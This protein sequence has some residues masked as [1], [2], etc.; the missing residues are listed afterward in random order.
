M[1]L[2]IVPRQ[3][4]QIEINIQVLGSQKKPVKT[5]DIKIVAGDA[6]EDQPSG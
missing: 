3:L 5:K 6:S 4:S 1:N 2:E